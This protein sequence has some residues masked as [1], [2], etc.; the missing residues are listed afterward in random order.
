MSGEDRTCPSEFDLHLRIITCISELSPTTRLSYCKLMEVFKFCSLAQVTRQYET[1]LHR[2]HRVC[3]LR[4]LALDLLLARTHK[5]GFCDQIHFL[6]FMMLDD[7]LTPRAGIKKYG[8]GRTTASTQALRVRREQFCGSPL[9]C[10]FL[11]L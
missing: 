10:S 2:L 1:E 8:L 5:G 6:A 4:S 9:N 11:E 3:L 7:V